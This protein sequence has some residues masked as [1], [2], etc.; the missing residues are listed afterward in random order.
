MYLRLLG[1]SPT[2]QLD[3]GHTGMPIQIWHSLQQTAH[4]KMC[5]F[6]TCAH[7]A[8]CIIELWAFNIT[9]LGARSSVESF[10]YMCMPASAQK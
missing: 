8:G 4:T 2:A 1:R 6:L 9:I 7:S 10:M 3:M 5:R